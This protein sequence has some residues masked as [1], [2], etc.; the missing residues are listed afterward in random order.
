MLLGFIGY[1][2]IT[3]CTEDKSVTCFGAENIYAISETTCLIRSVTKS[4]KTV[5]AYTKFSHFM[6]LQSS[7]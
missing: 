7:K 4:P 1:V 6:R 5:G 3:K 2:P